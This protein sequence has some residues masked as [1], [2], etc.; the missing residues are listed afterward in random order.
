MA[1]SSMCCE[2]Q[3]F[4]GGLSLAH[5]TQQIVQTRVHQTGKT[6]QYTMKTTGKKHV[7]LWPSGPGFDSAP[8]LYQLKPF[9]CVWLCNQKNRES[10]MQN[11][12]ITSSVFP[13][14][15]T[16]QTSSLWLSVPLP[17]QWWQWREGVS[18]GRLSAHCCPR[19]QHS[20]C[21]WCL[22]WQCT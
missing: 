4:S 5:V 20:A 22:K 16:F 19:Q 8:G 9:V 12:L 17:E 15:F 14:F 11:I 10:K 6:K 1:T 7:P 18:A 2:S 13:T 3:H 21:T